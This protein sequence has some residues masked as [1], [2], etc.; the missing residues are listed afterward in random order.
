M[1]TTHIFAC[2]A[3]LCPVASADT[4]PPALEATAPQES[5][6]ATRMADR[7]C[8]ILEALEH[9]QNKTEAD[10]LA[11]QLMAWQAEQQQQK[12]YKHR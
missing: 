12:C 10:Q 8:R 1:N 2:L 4:L 9:I 6:A 7:L 5:A 11:R 3:T